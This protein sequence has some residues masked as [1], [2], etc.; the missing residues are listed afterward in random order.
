MSRKTTITAKAAIL[1]SAAMLTGCAFV[2]DTV[3]PTYEPATNVTKIPGASTV[4]LAITVKNDKRNRSVVSVTKD[5]YGISMANVYMHVRKDFKRAF[6]TAMKSRGFQTQKNSVATVVVVVH[7]FYFTPHPGLWSGSQTGN[8]NISVKV[9]EDG[10]QIYNRS[11]N[12]NYEKRDLSGLFTQYR[13]A[14]A[15]NM[16]SHIVSKVFANQ[17]FI[18]ALFRAAGKTPPADLGVT[19]PASVSAH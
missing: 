2:P 1:I 14:T 18:D 15:K 8:A 12:Y 11:F 16:L 17:G 6:V 10:K 3:R 13:E 5:S 4:T 9:E 19:V 7:K